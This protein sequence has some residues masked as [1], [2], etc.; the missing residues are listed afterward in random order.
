[1]IKKLALLIATYAASSVFGAPTTTQVTDVDVFQFALTLEH[2]ENAFYSGALAKYSEQDFENAGFPSWVRGRFAQIA[3]HE[4]AHVKLLT[5]VLGENATQ[6][7]EYDFMYDS[8]R[9]FAAIAMV[10]ETVGGS[11]YLGAA[12]YI[13]NKDYLTTAA[14]ILA[15]E[16][17]HSS[18]ISSSVLNQQPWNGPLD[19]ALVPSGAFSLAAQFIKKCPSS[20][21]A[22]PVKSFPALT[23]SNASPASGSQI[24]V[25]IA[26][27]SKTG[28]AKKH[29]KTY[30]A[31]LNSF[32]VV[33]SDID[34]HGNTVVPS[35][36]AGTVYAAVVS[37]KK[38]MPS[39]ATLVSGFAVVQFPFGANAA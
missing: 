7:C 12:Q 38:Q 25:K 1:M 22:L 16:S 21:P 39:D 15:V 11:A 29:G 32:Q 4:A 33:Y 26:D 13:S 30:M 35:G 28:F 10:L 20:N 23:L 3:G 19:N 2:L 24:T 6:P 9:S 17:R 27:S 8:P 36:L 37:S 31:W 18:W 14:S 34:G 5:S